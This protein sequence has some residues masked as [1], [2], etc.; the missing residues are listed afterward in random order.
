[1]I[2]TTAAEAV[3]DD[4]IIVCHAFFTYRLRCLNVCLLGPADDTILLF[5]DQSDYRRQ[6][7]PDNYTKHLLKSIQIAL[8]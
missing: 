2:L 8:N 7:L 6:I 5:D 1:M 3:P 4:V